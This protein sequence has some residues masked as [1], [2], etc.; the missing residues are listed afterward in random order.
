MVILGSKRRNFGLWE[1]LL[2]S[3]YTLLNDEYLEGL[4]KMK[5]WGVNFIFGASRIFNLSNCYGVYLTGKD[6]LVGL[7]W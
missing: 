7:L 3:S 1:T 4:K 5:P 2:F 6:T